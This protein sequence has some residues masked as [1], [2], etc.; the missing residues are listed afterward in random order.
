MDFLIKVGDL[1]YFDDEKFFGGGELEDRIVSR[2]DAPAYDLEMVGEMMAN[3]LS[4]EI[5]DSNKKINFEVE[6]I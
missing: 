6:M 2:E 1:G 5:S 4:Y 3:I